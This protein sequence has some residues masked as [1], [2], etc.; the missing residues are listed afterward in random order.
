VGGETF[1]GS[2]RLDEVLY[3]VPGDTEVYL[4]AS[5]ADEAD[6]EHTVAAVNSD[7]TR[8]R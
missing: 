5:V 7:Y 1:A 2:F 3:T 6:V 8:S 4:S